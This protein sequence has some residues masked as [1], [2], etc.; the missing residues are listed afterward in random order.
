MR[1]FAINAFAALCLVYQVSAAWGFALPAAN[2]LERTVGQAQAVIVFKV[3]SLDIK[4]KPVPK[5]DPGG[6]Y[7]GTDAAIA[8]SIFQ[9]EGTYDLT[10]VKNIK[11]DVGSQLAIQFPALSTLGYASASMMGEIPP[12]QVKAGDFLVAFLRK[13]NG[14]WTAQDPWRPFVPLFSAPDLAATPEG[15]PLQ[16]VQSLIMPQLKDEATRLMAAD[17]LSQASNPQVLV[18][19]APYAQDPNLRVR[20]FV[21]SAMARN[22]QLG[23]IPLIRNLNRLTNAAGRGNPKAIILLPNYAGIKE[24]VPLLNPL[25]F[26]NEYFIRT[27]T[28]ATLGRSKDA[29][30]LPFLLLTLYDAAHGKENEPDAYAMFSVISGAKLSVGAGDFERNPDQARKAAWG[31]WQDEL[32]GKHPAA[33][34]A[35]APAVTLAPDQKFAAADLPQLNLG[36]F[37][38]SETTRRAAARGLEGLADASS[39]PYLLVALYDPLPDVAYTAYTTLHRLVPELGPASARALWQTQREAQTTAAFEWWQKHLLEA[40]KPPAPKPQPALIR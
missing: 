30:S 39:T 25:L 34:N 15:T 5:L 18:A 9:G 19:L 32:A 21:L 28:L 23:A 24:A 3:D 31:W 29:S 14:V 7:L 33:E 11:G 12:F 22:R 26:E 17:L 6:A 16:Q 40:D 20:D 2:S 8:M 27:N 1:R 38:L 37:M 10:A 13:E 36:L 35:P 4:A